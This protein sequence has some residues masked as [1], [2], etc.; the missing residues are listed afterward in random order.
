VAEFIDQVVEK[1]SV[2]SC[3][4]KARPIN[5][6]TNLITDLNA[7][8][9]QRATFNMYF[10][11]SRQLLTLI[12]FQQKTT[13]NFLTFNFLTFNFNKKNFFELKYYINEQLY[14]VLP[15]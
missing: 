11:V 1:T 15:I 5:S 6:G 10:I 9:H 14:T 8:G 7:M 12:I 13:F 3:F 4:A 2:L